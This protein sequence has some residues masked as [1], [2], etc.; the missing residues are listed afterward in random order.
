MCARD[1]LVAARVASPRRH[2]VIVCVCRA[3][4]AL[5]RR[6]GHAAPHSMCGGGD[7]QPRTRCALM[8]ATPSRPGARCG[9]AEG[10]VYTPQCRRASAIGESPGRALPLAKAS[11]VSSS[12]LIECVRVFSTQITVLLTSTPYTVARSRTAVWTVRFLQALIA[13]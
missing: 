11:R 10:P 3:E 12:S 9:G 7:T 2:T 4:G 5:V 8:C 13:L 1:G 6:R